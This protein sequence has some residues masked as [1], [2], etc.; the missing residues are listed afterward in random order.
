MQCL[1]DH[2]MRV[3]DNKVFRI[4]K[5]GIILKKVAGNIVINHGHFDMAGN[6]LAQK[7]FIVAHTKG[8]H[9][10]TFEHSGQG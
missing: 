9:A 7:S 3:V 10:G 1:F 2:Q 6:E 4:A 8:I 5:A